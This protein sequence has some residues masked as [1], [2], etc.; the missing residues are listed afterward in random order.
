MMVDQCRAACRGQTM[1][2]RERASVVAGVY[3]RGPSELSSMACRAV[4][5]RR[6]AEQATVSSKLVL[7]CRPDG[8]SAHERRTR[9]SQAHQR[10][11]DEC[12]GSARWEVRVK[13]IARI[14]S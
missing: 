4:P 8:D 5:R 12:E 14:V 11:R 1:S 9:A 3:E 10:R 7:R 2:A 6:R 13:T